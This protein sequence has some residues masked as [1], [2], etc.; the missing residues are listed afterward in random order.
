MRVWITTTGMSTTYSCWR[1]PPPTSRN[2][3]KASAN[4]RSARNP[5]VSTSTASWNRLPAALPK[6]ESND[7]ALSETK[8]YKMKTK[9]PEGFH[10]DPLGPN[11]QALYYHAGQYAAKTRPR[12]CDS[13]VAFY[14]PL[15]E[16]SHRCATCFQCEGE[17]EWS[18]IDR[19]RANVLPGFV[20]KRTKWRK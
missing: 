7:A 13:L 20:P 5:A 11:P 16:Y 8:T 2:G 6:M 10:R 1:P 3:C 12:R 4:F 17:L 14:V 15:L 9:P 19:A 18:T